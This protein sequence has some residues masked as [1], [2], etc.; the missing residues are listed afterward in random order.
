MKKLR[1]LH[2]SSIGIWDIEKGK[3]RI[4]TYLPLRGFVERGHS[5]LFLSGY[6]TVKT[7]EEDGISIKR[8]HIPF[9]Q[10]RPLVRFLF[11]PLIDLCYFISLYRTAKKYKPDVIY[12]HTTDTSAPARW[13]SKRVGCKFVVR[14][15][16]VGRGNDKHL[17][18]YP[19]YFMR[20]RCLGHKADAFILTNDG[21]GADKIAMQL[22]V[23]GTKIYFLKNGIEK[24]INITRDAS[25]KNQFA[26]GGE[27]L[28][29]SVCRL[30]KSKQ[31]DL[32]IKMM[33]GLTKL[34]PSKLIVIG[35]GAE[36]AALEELSASLRIEKNIMFLGALP[37]EK[38]YKYLCIADLFVSMN[39]LSS[40]SNPVYEASVCALPIIALNRGTTKEFIQ[41]GYNG[42]VV[43]E[44]QL[45]ELPQMVCGLL[46]SPQECERLGNN[47]RDYILKEWPSWEERVKNEVDIVE[48]ICG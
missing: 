48:Q 17:R 13:V 2:I 42:I 16:G 5:V 6:K 7:G 39:A 8:I 47:A 3:G 34:L 30:E 19:S 36:R 20:K 28:V 21:T 41:N 33:A 9:S 23:P 44:S 27:K 29:I 46:S 31:V 37:Q 43:E 40:M 1:T 15:Y 10:S 24:N 25:L 12:A 32:I 14:L 45:D 35:D 4:S 26:P 18:H 22:G 11:T 38:I